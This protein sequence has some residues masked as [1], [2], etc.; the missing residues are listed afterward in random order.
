LLLRSG[1]LFF[2]LSVWSLAQTKY[3]GREVC[4]GCHKAIAATQAQTAMALTWQGTIPKQVRPNSQETQVEGPDPLIHY[5][6]RR[7]GNKLAWEVGMPGQTP[8]Q[9]P[10]EI[11]MGGKRHGLSF[12]ARVTNLDGL[13]LARAPLVET[14][15]LHYAPEGRLELSP[16]F[17]KDKP[18]NYETA[19]G[20]VLTPHFEE[21]CLACHG[22]PGSLAPHLESGV[23]CESCHGPGQAHLKALANKSSDKGI[24]NPGRLPVAEQMQ[25]CSRCHAG[26][27]NVV[28][29]MPDDLLISDQVRALSNSEC[30][31]QSAG[32]ITCVNCHNPH[33]DSPR[34]TL[35]VKSEKTCL[36][37]HSASVAKHAAL[38]PVNRTSGCVGCHMPD[39]KHNTPFVISDHWIRVHPEQNVEVPKH[40]P[41]WT[42]KVVPRHLFVCLMV[43][44]DGAKAAAVREQLA[45]GSSFF[46]LARTNSADRASAINGGYLGD[47]DAN[48]LNPAWAQAALV[49]KPGE[50]SPVIAVQGRYFIVGRMPRNFREEAEARFNHAMELRKAGDR[51]QTAAELVEALKIDPYLLRALTYLGITYAESGNP[52]V[53]AGVLGLATRLYP[54]DAGARFNLGVAYGAMGNSEEIDEYRK[55]LDI[56]P[57]Y[58]PAYLNWGSALFLKGQYDEAVKVYREGINVDPLE[59][60]LHYSLSLALERENKGQEAQAERALAQKIDPKTGAAR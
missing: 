51:Q 53:G 50:V 16:G 7:A 46:D 13:P 49:L 17:P 21:K 34:A 8:L 35:V 27:S 10:I 30:W 54:Q 41:Q 59:A 25:P 60:S 39:S 55:A 22:A 26:F 33:Q 19:I 4:A 9:F 37:C 52:Q 43:L 45:S 58:V 44:D 36:G 31:R 15:Y 57:D 6:I 23:T 2:F 48:E 12:L 3:L 14:R 18:T 29:P 42:S 40:S 32:R 24:L 47:L 28:D 56:D 11:T 1:L 20:R 38:C 5:S